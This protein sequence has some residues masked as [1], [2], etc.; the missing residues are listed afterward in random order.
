MA[1]N[2]PYLNANLS[3]QS[4]LN[5]PYLLTGVTGI[6]SDLTSVQSMWVQSR[7]S[8]GGPVILGG[9]L[10]SPTTLN[11]T[12]ARFFSRQTSASGTSLVNQDG[13][14]SI[15]NLSLT[16]CTLQFRSGATTYTFRADAASVL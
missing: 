13:E 2:T 6:T 10:A 16:S 4:N 7:F 12:F 8:V 3:S 5:S 14:I 15:T 11:A 9:T 1:M